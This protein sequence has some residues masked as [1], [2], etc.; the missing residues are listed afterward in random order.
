EELTEEEQTEL[1]ELK[2]QFSDG[3]TG[4]VSENE[5]TTEPDKKA[6]DGQSGDEQSDGTKEENQEEAGEDAEEEKE[7]KTVQFDPETGY[8]IDPTTGT[9]LNPETGQPI[10]AAISDLSGI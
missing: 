1:A 2:Q 4:A 7:E 8:P 3:S 9:L 10:N 5:I 6:E